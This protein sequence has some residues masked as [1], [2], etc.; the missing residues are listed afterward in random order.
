MALNSGRDVLFVATAEARDG[1]MRRRIEEHR[2]MRPSGWTTLEATGQLGEQIARNIGRSRTVV[3]D[4]VTL[5]VS[6][7]FEEHAGSSDLEKEV[8]AEIEGIIDCTRQAEADFIIVTNEVGLGIIPG[9]RVSRLYRDILGRANQRL[10]V[11]ADEVLLLVAGIPV[12][13]K[14][15]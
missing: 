12:T 4:C 13:I 8:M 7:V 3:I 5:L 11:H 6:N 10:A 1:E 9:D 14:K 15:G 2:K